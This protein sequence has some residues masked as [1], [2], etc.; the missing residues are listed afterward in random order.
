MP[1]LS[2]MQLEDAK[3]ERELLMES[4]EEAKKEW[5]RIQSNLNYIQ[6]QE[7]ID[8]TIYALQAAEKRYVYLLRQMKRLEAK[9]PIS[10]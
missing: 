5:Q 2:R 10:W 1:L 8:Y 7:V 3:D 4:I 6:D 9:Q